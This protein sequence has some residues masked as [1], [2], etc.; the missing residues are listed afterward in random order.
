MMKTLE[1]KKIAKVVKSN[2]L[3]SDRI[4]Y[5]RKMGYQV[6]KLPM[7]PGGVL[8]QKNMANGQ[9]RIQVGYGQGRYNYAATVI[10]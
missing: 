3:V 9:T 1:F 5:L 2:R 7:G 10:L 4:D 6:E 8:Q